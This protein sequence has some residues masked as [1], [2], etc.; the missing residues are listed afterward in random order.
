[1]VCRCDAPEKV[2]RAIALERDY[3]QQHD[4]EIVHN[5]DIDK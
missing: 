2:R 1:M 5:R 3:I 4:A